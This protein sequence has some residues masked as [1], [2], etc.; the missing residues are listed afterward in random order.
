MSYIYIYIYIYDI[1]KLRV[2]KQVYKFSSL[3]KTF[4]AAKLK[5]NSLE[6]RKSS[7]SLSLSMGV[8]VTSPIVTLPGF[9]FPCINNKEFKLCSYLYKNVSN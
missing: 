2:S 7:V 9:Y 8:N 6:R 4:A 3:P 1:S 5:R